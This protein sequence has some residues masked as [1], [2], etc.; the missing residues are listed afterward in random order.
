MV[1]QL[2]RISIK[3]LLGVCQTTASHISFAGVWFTSLETLDKAEVAELLEKKTLYPS[4]HRKGFDD[5][6]LTFAISLTTAAKTATGLKKS[7]SILV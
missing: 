6:P 5:G 2:Y 3:A 1:N 4:M 7:T